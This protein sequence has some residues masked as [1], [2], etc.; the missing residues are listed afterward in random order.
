MKNKLLTTFQDDLKDRLENKTFKKV[1]LESETEY[2]LAKQMI[3]S[4]L[5]KKISQ[6]ELARKVKTT[7]AIISRVET[8]RANPSL[9]LIK[10]IARALGTEFS[11]Q[12]K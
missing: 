10:R 1:W 3:E 5:E 7:Q 8:M 4:R 11:L 2:L 6:R 12:I 9:S